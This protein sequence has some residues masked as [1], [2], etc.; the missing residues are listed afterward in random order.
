MGVLVLISTYYLSAFLNAK[1]PLT[2]LEVRVPGCCYCCRLTG[3]KAVKH[4]ARNFRS[5]RPS[6]VNASRPPRNRP[7]SSKAHFQTQNAY[8]YMRMGRI[9]T[10]IFSPGSLV[11]AFPQN[12]NLPGTVRYGAMYPTGSPYPL[13]TPPQKV[14]QT[15]ENLGHFF[16]VLVLRF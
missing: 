11:M 16:R 2:L 12:S 6:L 7:A 14:F 13:S 3:K 9:A 1:V 8:F 5:E 10:R 15:S 4:R